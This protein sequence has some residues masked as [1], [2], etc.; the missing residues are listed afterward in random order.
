MSVIEC[1]LCHD[2][3][4]SFACIRAAHN[5]TRCK[6]CGADVTGEVF[7]HI[8]YCPAL[9]AKIMEKALH[10]MTPDERR[11]QAI[12]FA[13][14]NIKMHQSDLQKEDVAAIYDELHSIGAA[15]DQQQAPAP[16]ANPA[17]WA[18]VMDDM[19]ARDA[20]GLAKYKTR[21]QPFNGRDALTDLYQ[22]LLDAVVYT[23]QLI[24]ER[25]GK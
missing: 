20:F 15:T 10:G 9:S 17:V 19:K 1:K 12:S 18:L 5:P 6:H 3:E 11:E 24:F 22:E 25:D 2:E 23:R 7:S 4:G 21:L 13:Y 14:G 8:M 16:N